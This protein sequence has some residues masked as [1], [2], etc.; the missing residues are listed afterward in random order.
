M[1]TSVKVGFVLTLGCTSLVMVSGYFMAQK[2][3]AYYEANP[4]SQ[5]HFEVNHSR[6]YTLH[7]CPVTIT[8]TTLSSGQSAVTITYA[9]KSVTLGVH[10]PAVPNFRDLSIYDE[11]LAVLSYV[12]ISRGKLDFDP[13]KGKDLRHVIVN[14]RSGG[15]DGYSPD[16]W[17]SVRIKDWTFDFVELLPDG[18]IRQ[19][20]MQFP[21][22]D[23]Q[24]GELYVP[25]KRENPD[26]PVDMIAE[27]SWQ[28]GAALFTVPRSQVSRYRY[29]TDAVAGT[30][31]S[32]G[33]GWTL[34]AAGFGVLGL[35]AGVTLLLAANVSR[36]AQQL[37]AAA[38]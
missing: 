18:T 2:V 13:T 10:A 3:A 16:T 35:F 6:T 36:K 31:G 9:D 24:T 29:R 20:I 26:A 33:M 12:P 27:R 25:I 38:T 14:R 17:G 21:A 32:D 7:D 30:D 19:S 15:A 23:R 28:W 34:P 37:K 1:R 5:W 11:F 4:A 8:D 22:R